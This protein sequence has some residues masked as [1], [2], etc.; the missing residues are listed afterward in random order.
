[1][2]INQLQIFFLLSL[3]PKGHTITTYI[4]FT[5]YQVM[6]AIYTGDLKYLGEYT[7]VIYKY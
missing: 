6:E 5:L 4:A 1:M 2:Y 3:F 7:K